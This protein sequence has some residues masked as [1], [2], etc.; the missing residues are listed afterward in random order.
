MASSKVGNPRNVADKRRVRRTIK[1]LQRVK[2]WQLLV[3]LLLVGFVAATFLRLNNIGMIER[4]TAVVTADESGD[5]D[6]LIKRLYDLQQYVSSHM[7]TDMG[8]GVYLES[9]Y[10]R[11]YQAWLA[12]QYGDQNPNGNI[13]KKAQEVC[14]P[15]FSGY[16][17]AYLQ[18]TTSELAKYPAASGPSSGE[19]A[20]QV[21]AYL[22]DY[23]SPVWSPDFAGWSLVICA[24]LVL[25]IIA[26]LVGLVIL[27]VMLH[28]HYRSI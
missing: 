6:V 11:D 16:S 5:Q 1:D 20:P 4:R 8:K 25:M 22:H 19:G 18:C 14:A 24:V 28:R 15:R 2:T 17:A 21:N 23:V 26:R 10:N 3:L 12:T 13:Y 7:N 9:S 27:R